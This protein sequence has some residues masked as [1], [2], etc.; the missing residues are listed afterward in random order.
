[1]PRSVTTSRLAGWVVFAIALLLL[2]HLGEPPKVM[3]S[4]MDQLGVHPEGRG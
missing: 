4:T 2:V 1:M 3:S